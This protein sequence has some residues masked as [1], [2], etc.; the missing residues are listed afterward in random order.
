MV[1]F[2]SPQSYH[3]DIEYNTNHPPQSSL[4]NGGV[5]PVESF[6]E[7]IEAAKKVQVANGY[8]FKVVIEPILYYQGCENDYIE[9]A[10]RLMREIDINQIEDISISTVR[11]GKSLRTVVKRNYPS[12]SLFDYPKMIE[13]PVKPDKKLRYNFDW[14]VDLYEELKAVFEKSSKANIRL[15]SEKPKA[16]DAVGLDKTAHIEKSVYQYPGK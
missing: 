9:L 3:G 13:E 6:N 2:S 12:T 7:R 4:D 16:W 8:K 14:R 15:G 5:I 11:F 10:K 1:R